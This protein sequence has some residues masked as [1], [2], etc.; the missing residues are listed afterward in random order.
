M[1]KQILFAALS[2]FLFCAAVQA[3]TTAFTYQ[4]RFTD[5]T[6]PQPTNGSYNMQFALFDS[7]GTQ[8]GAIVT[9]ANV[10]VT[11]GIFTVSLDFGA[12]SFDGTARLL[13]IRVFNQATSAYVVLNPRQPIT[14]T[15]L[16]IRALNAA[17]ADVSTNTLNVGGTPAANIIKE[18]DA[19][20]TDTR[21]PTA[22]SANYIQ[23][24]NTLIQPLAAFTISGNGEAESFNARAVFAIGGDRVLSIGGVNNLFAGVG[25]GA[26]NAAGSYNSFVGTNAGLRNTA[27]SFNSFFG[28][29]AGQ[30]N[31]TGINNSF[32]GFN[33][34]YSN[35]TGSFNAFLGRNAGFSNTTGGDNSFVGYEAGAG[36]STGSNNSFVGSQ[37]GLSNTT[38]SNNSF[39]GRSAGLSNTTG[40]SNSFVGVDAGRSNT[41]GIGNSFFGVTTGISNV[42]GSDN[43]FVGANAGFSNT[44]GNGNSFVGVGAGFNNTTGGNNT[45]IGYFADVAAG[46]LTFAAAFGTN[47][48][49]SQSDTIVL[50]KVAGTY[51]SVVRPADTV[52]IPGNLNVIGTFGNVVNA[53]T[54]YNIGGGRVLSVAGTD[55]TFA[56]FNTGTVNTGIS[57]SFFGRNSGSSNTSGGNNSFFGRD[58]GRNNSTGATNSFFGVNAGLNNTSGSENVFL[59]VQAGSAN[60]TGG[61]NTILGTSA[62]VAANN[63][64]FATALGSGAVVSDNNTVVL[65]RSADTVRIPGNL[66]VVGTFT[67]NISGATLTNLNASNITTGT[68]A[69]ARLGIIPIANGGTG[70]ATQNFVD[71]TNAQTIGGNK[72]FSAT[73]TGNIVNSA[74]QYDIAGNRVFSVSGTQFNTFVGLRTGA[75][76]TTGTNNV[77][78][79]E[80]AGLVNNAGSSNLLVGVEAGRFNTTG[81]DNTFVGNRAGYTNTTGSANTLIGA[82]ADVGVSNLTNA[83]A[84]G[85]GATVFSSNT[86]AL[87]RSNGNDKVVIYGLGGG[88]LIQLCRNSDN[89]ISTCSSSLRYKTNIALFNSGLSLVKRLSPITFDWKTGGLRDLGLG[90]ED[91]AAIEPLLVTYNKDGQVEGVKYDRIGVVLLNAVKEQQTQI[92]RQQR[93]INELKQIVCS[94]K[95][96]APVCQ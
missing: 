39:V 65:G 89:I 86:I 75:Q 78:V 40:G 10:Q 49:V 55:N 96:D 42:T 33:A 84:I 68:L 41:T 50:G 46:N 94:I 34:G 80:T 20:L 27:G 24:Q 19:R 29:D 14:S 93:Q 36:N 38:G 32:L 69:N 3:Q 74:T 53:E 16:A 70:S 35:T 72:T 51:N 76:I 91:V 17:T 88:G 79:G 23:N 31:T 52:I 87:G 48:V 18:G 45:I 21:T 8:S 60:T 15:P 63:L 43:S 62:N 92:E 5:T 47:A 30:A 95:P 81:N 85:A 73:L 6:A 37:T 82:N 44:A 61:N 54:Q 4:G 25:S 26:A 57:N 77:F 90:A 12:N 59:G 83:T 58:A 66:N 13:E 11:N 71:L 22:G 67:G 2:I 7:S 56:G 64:T 1:K 9:N 28:S